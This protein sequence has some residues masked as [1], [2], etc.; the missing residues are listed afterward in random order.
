MQMKWF[1]DQALALKEKRI[2][3]GMKDFGTDPNAYGTWIADVERPA[4]Q[5]R[6]RY[7]ERLKEARDL[8]SGKGS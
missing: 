4:A 1:F 7:H 2:G 3:D 6:G 5:Y 8:I